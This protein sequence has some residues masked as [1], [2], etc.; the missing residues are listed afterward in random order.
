MI[1][2]ILL[3]LF[4]FS[5]GIT[6]VYNMRIA[7]AT[8]RQHGSL[9]GYHPKPS[10]GAVTLVNTDRSTYNGIHQQVNGLLLTVLSSYKRA[11]IRVDS[12][13]AHNRQKIPAVGSRSR[14]QMDDLLF[15][16]GYSFAAGDNVRMSVSGLF[17]I[18][19]HKDTGFICPEVGTGHVGLGGQIDAAW[20]YQKK[21]ALLGA[22]RFIH[23]F[24]RQTPL[25][26]PTVI[27][28]CM[29]IDFHLG[30]V[31]DLFLAHQCN[32]GRHKWEIGYNPTF[33]FDARICPELSFIGSLVN[34][35]GFIRSSFYTSYLC[36]FLIREHGSAIILGLSYSFDHKPP[37]FGI[38]RGITVWGT[39]GI[40]F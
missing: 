23:F 9:A 26:A 1:F 30:N 32:W 3:A 5:D 10:I 20:F 18:P 38:K 11:Y 7:E 17:G 37:E 19:L 13:F 16:G 24:T 34:Q 8:K 15:T 25:I 28:T 27:P 6:L 29:K 39:W 31:A 35:I 4:F 22:S 2:F 12:A 40:N 14:T 33:A 21:Y 36:K